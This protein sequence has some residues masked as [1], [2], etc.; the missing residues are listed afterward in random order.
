[1][2]RRMGIAILPVSLGVIDDDGFAVLRTSA[3]RSW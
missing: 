1:M 3:H 2:K